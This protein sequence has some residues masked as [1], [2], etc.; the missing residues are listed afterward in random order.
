M[1]GDGEFLSVNQL[2]NGKFERAPLL[3]TILLMGRNGIVDLRL[4]TIVSQIALQ[5]IATGT[6]N[7]EDVVNAIAI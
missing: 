1:A 7:G 2:S 5:F 4:D 3:I 6:E